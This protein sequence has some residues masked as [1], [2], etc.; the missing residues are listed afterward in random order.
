[1]GRSG[2]EGREVVGGRRLL[3][4]VWKDAR[5]GRLQSGRKAKCSGREEAGGRKSSEMHRAR[6]RRGLGQGKVQ[7][8]G[9]WKGRGGAGLAAAGVVVTP[10]QR[11]DPGH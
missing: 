8:E 5:D 2:L 9:S 4:R 7:R 1:M 11:N 6:G 3:A 10:G